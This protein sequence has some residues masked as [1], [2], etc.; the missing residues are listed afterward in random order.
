MVQDGESTPNPR[1][2]PMGGARHHAIRLLLV[3]RSYIQPRPVLLPSC[4]LASRPPRLRPVG[5]WAL[6]WRTASLPTRASPPAWRVSTQ[7]RSSK[8][9]T[10]PEPRDSDEWD[11]R[12]IY[13]TFDEDTTVCDRG[14]SVC[15]PSRSSISCGKESQASGGDPIWALEG[16]NKKPSPE[17]AGKVRRTARAA[18]PCASLCP[19]NRLQCHCRQPGHCPPLQD[20]V[21]GRHWRQ[22]VGHHPHD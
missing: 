20:H 15:P 22:S 17:A 11:I 9:G 13:I 21:L 19:A 7:A 6:R 2:G 10:P 8:F 4:A 1:R 14:G 18:L 3:V 16:S 5:I 12:S